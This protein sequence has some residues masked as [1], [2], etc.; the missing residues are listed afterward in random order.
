ML[1]LLL[2]F[3]LIDRKECSLQQEVH[4]YVQA[5]DLRQ[6]ECRRRHQFPLKSLSQRVH[7]QC[8]VLVLLLNQI[9]EQ[10]LHGAHS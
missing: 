2:P 8:V 5:Y 6:G 9:Q 1:D 4:S 10:S 7:E 3:Q